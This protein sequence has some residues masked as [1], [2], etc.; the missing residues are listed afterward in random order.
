M[1]LPVEHDVLQSREIEEDTNQKRVD[2]EAAT[3]RLSYKVVVNSV[4]GSPDG[5]V[6]SRLCRDRRNIAFRTD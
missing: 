5:L 3:M 2:S 1:G 4:L 6:S